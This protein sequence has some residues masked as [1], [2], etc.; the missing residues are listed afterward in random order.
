MSDLSNVALRA[1]LKTAQCDRVMLKRGET[2]TNRKGKTSVDEDTK[3]L[4]NESAKNRESD[5]TKKAMK[6]KK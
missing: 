4:D 1:C 2:R 5:D 3:S 6:T